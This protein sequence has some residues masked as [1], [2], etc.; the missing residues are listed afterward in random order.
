MKKKI[1]WVSQRLNVSKLKIHPSVQ[2]EFDM[3]HGQA[4]AKNWQSL[5]AR[6]LIVVQ[7]T[8]GDHGF[9]VVDGQHTRWAAEKVGE[10][11]LDCRVIRVKTKAEMNEI[12]HLVNSGVKHISPID[13]YGMNSR[14]DRTTADAVSNQILEECNLSVGRGTRSPHRISAVQPVRKAFAALGIERFATAASLWEV[15]ANNGNRLGAEVIGAVSQVIQERGTDQELIVDLAELFD[16]RFGQIHSDATMKCIG[17]T[18]SANPHVLA[19]TILEELD[20]NV[21]YARRAA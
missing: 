1:E 2:R 12:F 13:S 5:V 17:A 8:S 20:G 3:A 9:Y 16:E 15:I 14:N 4:I 10:K 11:F 7:M 21:G 19:R 6:P 18:L